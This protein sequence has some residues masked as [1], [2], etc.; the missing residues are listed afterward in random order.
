MKQLLPI[1]LFLNN[2]RLGFVK[3]I[4]INNQNQFHMTPFMLKHTQ[5]YMLENK[6]MQGL[7]S[8]VQESA[9]EEDSAEVLQAASLDILDKDYVKKKKI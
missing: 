1:V 8:F 9:E 7:S 2:D 6:D 3:S 4:Q 5:Q